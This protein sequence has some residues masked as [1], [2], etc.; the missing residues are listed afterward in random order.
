MYGRRERKRERKRESTRLFFHC[1]SPP[2]A[3]LR[4]R[5]QVLLRKKLFSLKQ[6]VHNFYS[7]LHDIVCSWSSLLYICAYTS[8]YFNSC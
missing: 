1:I 5:H 2:Q 6:Q 8:G 7:Q 3:R 4:D